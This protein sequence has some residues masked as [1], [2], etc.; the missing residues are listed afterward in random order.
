[1]TRHST[2]TLALLRRASF[3][4]WP[5]PRPP[6]DSSPPSGFPLH[7][8]RQGLRAPRT[9]TAR[10]LSLFHSR[11]RRRAPSVSSQAS[12]VAP[13]CSAPASGRVLPLTP[14][15]RLP[16]NTSS[17]F[18]PRFR[19]DEE[20]I[21]LEQNQRIKSL[22]RAPSD[23]PA[24]I[25]KGEDVNGK[26]FPLPMHVQRRQRL[27][28]GSRGRKRSRPSNSLAA[29]SLRHRCLLQSRIRLAVLMCRV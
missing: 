11:R 28:E 22:N 23:F 15:P 2:C 10:R 14:P 21:L 17:E 20:R 9:P 6:D 8:L 24:F 3:E 12:M 25:R 16:A 7:S 13:A 4:S 27:E 1:M 26:G 18:N 29:F 19:A 5:G